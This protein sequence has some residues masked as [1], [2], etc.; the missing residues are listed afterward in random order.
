METHNVR[1][2]TRGLFETRVQDSNLM[3]ERQGCGMKHFEVKK[4]SIITE[5][6]AVG[7]QN[8]S[9]LHVRNQVRLRTHFGDWTAE[10][11]RPSQAG[12]G[13]CDKSEMTEEGEEFMNEMSNLWN[14]PKHTEASNSL[15]DGARSVLERKRELRHAI[16]EC[17]K[18]M[19]I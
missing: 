5:L 10:C 16:A 6:K 11:I 7:S 13:D 15:L 1:F 17:G 18:D 12:L 3:R 4:A 19:G 8:A 2:E 9:M 14:E